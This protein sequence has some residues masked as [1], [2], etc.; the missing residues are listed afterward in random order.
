[1]SGFRRKHCHI[2]LIFGQFFRYIY[3]FTAKNGTNE[4]SH[5]HFIHR[6]LIPNMDD[7]IIKKECKVNVWD[8]FT[9][10]YF[11]LLLYNLIIHYN[12]NYNKLRIG[13]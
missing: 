10:K 8:Y 11:Q 4:N 6:M 1:L 2:A 7:T 12:I 13:R 3:Y 5:F 9:E